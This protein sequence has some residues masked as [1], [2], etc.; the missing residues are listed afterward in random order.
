MRERKSFLS[1]L[2]MMGNTSTTIS[3]QIKLRPVSHWNLV[4]LPKYERTT[5]HHKLI[6]SSSA[7]WRSRRLLFTPPS[8]IPARHSCDNCAKLECVLHRQYWLLSYDK[9]FLATV[10]S[11]FW[12]LSVYRINLYLNHPFVLSFAV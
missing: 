7:F 9:L 12:F 6:C 3:C 8:S 1:I 4:C 5:R 10:A 2:N 11:T